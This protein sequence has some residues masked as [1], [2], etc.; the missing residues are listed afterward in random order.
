MK[1]ASK[2]YKTKYYLLKVYAVLKIL[3]LQ[4]F[5]KLCLDKS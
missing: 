4:K 5:L 3:I 1:R 2:I